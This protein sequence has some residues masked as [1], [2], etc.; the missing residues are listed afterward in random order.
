M[1]PNL[2][3]QQS[4]KVRNN[5]W[6]I[7]KCLILNSIQLPQMTQKAFFSIFISKILTWELVL[8]LTIAECKRGLHSMQYASFVF[9]STMKSKQINPLNLLAETKFFNHCFMPSCSVTVKFTCTGLDGQIWKNKKYIKRGQIINNL[10]ISKFNC[11][12]RQRTK[13]VSCN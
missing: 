10:Q 11:L 5:E 9:L 3:R 7:Y 1:L 13:K 2:L 12:V 4:F 8:K 6:E